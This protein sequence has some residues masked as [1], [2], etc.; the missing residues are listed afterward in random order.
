M[1]PDDGR[2]VNP[3]LGVLGGEAADQ[4]AP[5][6]RARTEGAPPFDVWSGI[7][8]RDGASRGDQTY[9]DRP[10][11]KHP[12]WKWYVPAYFYAGGAAGAAAVLGAAAQVADREGLDGLIRRSRWVAAVGGAVGT[13]LLIADLG[14]PK[15]FLN[16][17]R[18][19]RP[20]SPM[21][22]GSWIL[23]G[24]G[25]SAAV[26]AVL[27][28]PGG[29]FGFLGD[30]SGLASG[31][32]GVPLSGYTG[33]LLAN[34]AVPVW[35]GTRRTVPPMFVASG[36][37]AAASLLQLLR[38][39]EREER[40]VRRF[41]LTASAADLVAET[42]M[43]REAS[44]VERVARP[45]HEG[46]S[47]ALLRAS[48]ILTAAALVLTLGS[49]RWPA[50]RRVAGIL[51]TFGAIAAKFGVVE[52]GKASTADPRATFHQQRAGLGGA[53]V[54]GRPAITSP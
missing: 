46:R 12:V 9:Y 2:N 32:A 44:T 34:T 54:T 48:K 36:A 30:V 38:L 47:G 16:M 24:L 14:R 28:R 19:F 49:R 8:S 5:A 7:P 6:D 18:V 21:N 20:T 1:R 42:A 51:G 39:D 35:Q 50:L 17:L 45:L 23:S 27:S 52:A 29:F 22:V 3:D 43:E 15:R 26:S 25:P 10:V 13:A 41:A 53:E 40:I 11:L 4:S 31:A 33:V 37:T